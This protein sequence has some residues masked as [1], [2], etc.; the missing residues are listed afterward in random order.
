MLGRLLSRTGLPA[1]RSLEHGS[2]R[3]VDE[4]SSTALTDAHNILKKRNKL[5]RSPIAVG[6]TELAM[7]GDCR[8]VETGVYRYASDLVPATPAE[9]QVILRG[10]QTSG[11]A[12]AQSQATYGRSELSDAAKQAAAALAPVTSKT[13]SK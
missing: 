9:R 11:S 2:R 3:N 8:P 13:H 6:T 7:L 5:A 10:Y 1:R 4:P 12:S